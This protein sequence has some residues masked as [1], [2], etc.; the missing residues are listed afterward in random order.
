MYFDS[1]NIFV[2]IYSSDFVCLPVCIWLYRPLLDLGRFS[3][4]SSFTQ[5]VG[6]LER[7]ISL[8]QGHYLHTQDSTN[9]E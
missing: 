5:S 8:S 6:V 3:V 9:A 7:G 2:K 4:P 1:S